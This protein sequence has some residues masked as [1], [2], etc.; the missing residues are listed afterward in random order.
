[1]SSANE[2][3]AKGASCLSRAAGDVE[4]AKLFRELAADYFAIAAAAVNSI[5]AVQQQQQIQ[6]E[7]QPSVLAGWPG[8]RANMPEKLEFAPD[9]WR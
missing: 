3:R 1:M 5:P 7:Q 8:I 6:P 9:Y 2:Y 4:T